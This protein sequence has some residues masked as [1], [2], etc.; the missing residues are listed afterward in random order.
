[1]SDLAQ[2]ISDGQMRGFMMIAKTDRN[3]A[4]SIAELP[5]GYYLTITHSTGSSYIQRNQGQLKVTQERPEDARE[6]KVYDFTK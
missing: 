2:R 4:T 5:D 3:F 6:N 1:M